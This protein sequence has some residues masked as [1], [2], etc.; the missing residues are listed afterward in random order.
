MRRTAGGDT[1]AEHRRRDSEDSGALEIE[2]EDEEAAPG[3]PAASAGRSRDLRPA[4][5]GTLGAVLL[6]AALWATHRAAP[7]SGPS[8]VVTPPAPP[9]YYAAVV[10]VS[11]HGSRLLS[12]PQRRIEVDLRV[13][14]VDGAQVKIIEYYISENGVQVRADPPPSTTPLPASGADVRLDLTVTDCAAVP[15]GES[16]AFVDVVADGPLGVLDRFT[17]L[18]ERYSADLARLLRTVC[19]ERT[20][21]QSQGAD[22]IVAVS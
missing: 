7:D 5:L 9:N 8:T 6:G 11:Y 22:T 13:A 2:F 20:N 1:A 21:G 10:N 12:L 4:A 15:I 14:P 19:P 17:I 16:M 18:G 3:Y